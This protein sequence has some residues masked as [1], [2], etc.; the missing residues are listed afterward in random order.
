M[1]S[2]VPLTESA[3]SEPLTQARWRRRIQSLLPDTFFLVAR[4]LRAGLSLEQAL[5]TVAENDAAVADPS[6]VMAD[7]SGAYVVGVSQWASFGKDQQTPTA[8]CAI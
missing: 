7:R 2:G 5:E 8:P 1:A 3:S 6:L 4:S